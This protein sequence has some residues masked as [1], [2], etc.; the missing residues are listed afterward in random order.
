V[1]AGEANRTHARRDLSRST[2]WMYIFTIFFYLS[3]VAAVGVNVGWDDPRLQA[4]SATPGSITS[5]NSPFIIAMMDNPTLSQ[6]GFPQA[7]KILFIISAIT[8][9]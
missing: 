6:L 8:T 7:F 1:A 2:K 4:W 5:E 3:S 9:A